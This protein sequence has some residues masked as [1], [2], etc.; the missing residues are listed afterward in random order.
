MSKSIPEKTEQLTPEIV[1]GVSN[2]RHSIWEGNKERKEVVYLA[3]K[4]VAIK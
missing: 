1:F 4:M 2:V 3:G